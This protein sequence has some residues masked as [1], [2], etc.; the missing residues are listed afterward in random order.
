MTARITPSG[1]NETYASRAV[2]TT[3]SGYSH[4]GPLKALK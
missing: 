4:I 3:I 1:S 2:V